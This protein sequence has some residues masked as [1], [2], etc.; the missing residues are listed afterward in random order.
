[1]LL[2]RNVSRYNDLIYLLSHSLFAFFPVFH[3]SSEIDRILWRRSL[4]F[5]NYVSFVFDF[6]EKTS[7]LILDNVFKVVIS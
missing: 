1:M 6:V 5:D 2:E 4:N 7:K 3:F